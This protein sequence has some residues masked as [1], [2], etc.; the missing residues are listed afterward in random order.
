[1][2]D[3]RAGLDAPLGVIPTL[4]RR[5]IV[6]MN[7]SAQ[8]QGPAG[9]LASAG[10][11]Q[12]SGDGSVPAVLALPDAPVGSGTGSV[13]GPLA[14]PVLGNAPVV[15]VPSS[16]GE[17]VASSTRSVRT[18]GLGT[19]IMRLPESAR[20]SLPD[21]PSSDDLFDDA[22]DEMSMDWAAPAAGSP[23]L[24]SA[25]SASGSAGALVMARSPDATGPHDAASVTGAS[26]AAGAPG[27]SAASELTV[28]PLVRIPRSGGTGAAAP[29]L[30][31]P[32]PLP[33]AGVLGTRVLSRSVS[34]TAPSVSP[35]TPSRGATVVA[36]M[37]R[38]ESA[39]P[40][41]AAGGR[42]SSPRLGMTSSVDVA[43][44]RN[45]DS[46]DREPEHAGLGPVHTASVPDHDP[47]PGATA[48]SAGSGPVSMRPHE[49]APFA[50]TPVTDVVRCTSSPWSP[51]AVAPIRIG[52][53]AHRAPAAG[54]LVLVGAGAA[55]TASIGSD[56]TTFGR[57]PSTPW[58]PDPEPTAPAEHPS[59]AWSSEVT[60]RV[61]A[62][63]R[64]PVH[65]SSVE[66][67][68]RT[69]LGRTGAAGEARAVGEGDGVVARRVDADPTPGVGGYSVTATNA[70]FES[71]MQR[72]GDEA[73][74]PPP[75]G[76][77]SA[78]G[79]A[80]GASAGGSDL[81]ALAQSLYERIRHRL[82]RELLDDRERAG[83]LLDRM[84]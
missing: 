39:P 33:M 74:A 22:S 47:L 53:A 55:A 83:F 23:G 49:D 32:L 11:V 25:E 54:P 17:D 37:R 67:A 19:P 29:A 70:A 57:A 60:H 24:R 58:Q 45:P 7:A 35:A 31:L 52:A 8:S 26:R 30:P 9:P 40:P 59:S 44:G 79:A 48:V 12:R 20:S 64:P 34:D 15:G 13:A 77:T 65:R 84:R 63:A 82:R 36:L 76:A 6:E 27:E 4:R 78:G 66:S 14:R 69:V 68:V 62:L 50:S 1:M 16:P 42:S 41:D 21:D 5:H 10:A 18:A 81:D 3:R 43:V 61:G 28:V 2:P 72:E 51:H 56:A 38:L 73:A 46:I 75:S 80:G 71:L